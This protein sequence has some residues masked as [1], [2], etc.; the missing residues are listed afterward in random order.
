MNSQIKSLFLNHKEG[1]LTEGEL[2]AKLILISANPEEVK[3]NLNDA[4]KISFDEWLNEFNNGAEIY[5]GKLEIMK[6]NES[7]DI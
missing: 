7:C 6:G 3:Q 1:I 5:L 2:F 4:Q